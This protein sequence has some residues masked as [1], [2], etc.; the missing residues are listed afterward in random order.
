MTRLLQPLLL[1][2][3]VLLQVGITFLQAYLFQLLFLQLLLKL[4][5]LFFNA[6]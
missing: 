5:L 3:I 4:L 6:V 2:C 1:L